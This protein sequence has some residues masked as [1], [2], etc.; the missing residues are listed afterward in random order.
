MEQKSQTHI[1]LDYNLLDNTNKRT[2]MLEKIKKVPFKKTEP[3]ID[4]IIIL[5]DSHQN[6][7]FM[8]SIN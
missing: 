4:K 3:L 5:L 6:Y 1:H 7:P 2:R 8:F